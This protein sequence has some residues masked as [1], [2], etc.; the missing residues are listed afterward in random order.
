MPENIPKKLKH[1]ILNWNI[2]ILYYVAE[3]QLLIYAI[4]TIRFHVNRNA[5][6]GGSEFYNSSSGCIVVCV[7]VCV[8]VCVYNF[9]K[10]LKNR[11]QSKNPY[12]II[13]QKWNK[14]IPLTLR[15]SRNRRSLYSISPNSTTSFGY[16]TVS[17]C[18]RFH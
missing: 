9:T 14:H 15:W 10:S 5:T 3:W 13:R 7:C 11:I 18:M 17:K 12:N 4:G 2:Y 8:C 6:A 1:G 16:W